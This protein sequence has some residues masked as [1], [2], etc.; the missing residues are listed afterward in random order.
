MFK[1][2]SAEIKKIVSKPGIYILSV[3]LAIILVLGVFIYKPKVYE[4]SIFE[5]DGSTYVEK[6]TTL[7]SDPN[8]G[9]KAKVD[10]EFNEIISAIN[11]YTITKSDKTYNYEEYINYLVDE[12]EKNMDAYWD[13]TSIIVNQNDID[14]TRIAIVNTLI[15]LNSTLENAIINYQNYAYTVVVTQKDYDNYKDIYSRILAWA[16]VEKIKDGTDSFKNHLLEYKYQYADKFNDILSKFIYPTLSPN[17]VKDYTENQEGTK[18]KTITQRKED[19]LNQ[20]ETNYVKATNTP[21]FNTSSSEL[22]DELANLYV[23]TVNTFVNLV[24]QELLVNAFE[25]VSTGDQLQLLTLSTYSEYNAKSLL[26][27]YE[28][29][30]ENNKTERDYSAPLTIGIASNGEINAYD[31]SYF[32]LRVFS[33]VIIVYAIMSACHTIAGEIK[34]GTMRYL[35]IRP[36]TRTSL[37]FGKWLAIMIMA[38]ILMVFSLIISLCVG[39]A[40][41]GFS[42]H[43]ILT[44]FNGTTPIVLHP[45]SMIGI[46]LI[47]MLAELIIY[48]LLAMLFSVLFKSDLMSMTI[49]LVLYLLN[50]LLPMFIQGA[51]TWLAFYPFSHISLYALYGSSLY[52]P[53]NDFFNLVFGAKVYA[54]TSLTLTVS[55]ITLMILITSFIALRIF[56][57][58][59]L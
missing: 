2:I 37:F 30:F 47:S 21:A 29:M 23:D 39:S 35:S 41:Y 52:A 46:Y 12:F 5:L 11:S 9:Q 49:L 4:S 59:E 33:F 50:T 7:M 42:S 20:I 34:E 14:K 6:Y 43:N 16:K 45:L 27:K 28:F 51:N 10:E 32:V 1:I 54:G 56:K 15:E 31:Y 17:L 8:K 55:V 36:V 58:K 24:K 48:S 19:I 13:Y 44:I 57:K 53:A 18:F 22:M 38:S 40:V 26:A 3:L 25:K